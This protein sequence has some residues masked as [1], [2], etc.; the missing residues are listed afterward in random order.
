MDRAL[1]MSMS[2]WAVMCILAHLGGHLAL[3]DI[4]VSLRQKFSALNIHAVLPGDPDYEK[5]STP[6]N[7]R[8][9][10]QPAA[11]VFPSNT[12]EVA[13][14]VKVGVGE[15]LLSKITSIYFIDCPV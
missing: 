11:I 15:K 12:N 1:A 3:A 2:I 8:L 5:F 10:Y 7:K 4:T 6:F 13:D 14:S 9:S